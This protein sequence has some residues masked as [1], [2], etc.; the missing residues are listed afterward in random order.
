MATKKLDVMPLCKKYLDDKQSFIL[1]GG[2]GSGKTESV[3]ELLLYLSNTNPSARVICITH[4]NTAVHEIEERIGNKYPVSTIHSFLHDLIKRYKK[5]IYSIIS[6]LYLVPE[7][8]RL[9][10]EDIENEKEY[11]KAEYDKFKKI[12]EKF[13]RK[14]YILKKETID[15]VTGK[16]E[17]DKD[18]ITYNALLNQQ[19]SDL[20]QY[21]IEKINSK[22]YMNIKYNETKFDSLDDLTYGHDGLLAITHLL[23]ERYPILSKIVT[24]K[25][26]YIFIDEYQDTCKEVIKDLLKL[27]KKNA[28]NRI[29]MCLFGDSM[30]A[31]YTNGVEEV[32]DVV[33]HGDLVV[34]P[35]EDNYRCSYEVIEIINT[36]RL[37]DIQQNVALARLP[38]GEIQD[39]NDRHGSVRVLYS[40]CDKRPHS[41]SSSEEKEAFSLKVDLLIKEAEKNNIQAKILL[42]TNKAIAEK[43][44]FKKL[45]ETFDKRYTEVN[46]RMENYLKRIQILDICD[47]CSSYKKEKYNITIKFV[48]RGG[49]II[50]NSQDKIKLQEIIQH[51]LSD[52]EISVSGAYQYALD[53]KLISATETSK[54]IIMSND[55]FKENL[56]K[57][58]KY[59]QF[60]DL[61]QKGL[62]TYARIR[63]SFD[64]GSEEEFNYYNDL[65][66]KENF[67]ETLFS[68]SIKFSEVL[69]YTNYL[70][71]AGKH[72]TMHKTKGSS[73]DSVIVVMEEYCWSEYDFSTIY[74]DKQAQL[75]QKQWMNSQKLIY[76]A[77]SRAKKSLVCIRLLLESEVECFKN[78][79]P[80]AEE[81]KFI[82]NK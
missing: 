72:I 80:N 2:A 51:L 56:L 76:V 42:L 57:N 52:R 79:F 40:I 13:A 16:R 44:G 19:I 58:T 37:D 1:Q 71:E 10:L 34:V 25:Y 62:N 18:P 78:K 49:Y 39:K 67:I 8:E 74:N 28:R 9:E 81:I 47:I 46:D 24:D 14:L 64:L 61:F 5:N 55:K 68:E 32:D 63:E 23:F 45:Y 41:R 7:M 6:P 27:I 12:Y 22:D 33:E 77:C 53:N 36:L 26:D 17:Y 30:Q 73:I 29:A 21:I 75:K 35:K 4:T 69:S 38:T 65:L 60:K 48:K 3:K 11:N 50:Q 59:Q 70:D 31:I 66:K 20:N 54:H 82:D 43:E 15:K